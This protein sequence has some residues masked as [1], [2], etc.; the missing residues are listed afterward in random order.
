MIE[1][2]GVKPNQKIIIAKD[3]NGLD[4]RFLILVLEGDDGIDI[5]DAVKKACEEYC[6]TEE[7]KETLD[8][9]CGCFNWADFEMHVPDEICEKHGFRKICSDVS[10]DEVDWN[11]QLI[12]MSYTG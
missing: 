5:M 6:S 2:K 8:Y 9:N 4:I 7:G 1:V 10:M 12:D 11:E 3:Q